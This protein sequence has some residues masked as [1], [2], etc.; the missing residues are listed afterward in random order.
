MADEELPHEGWPGVDAATIATTE[1][2]PKDGGGY[3]DDVK[4][5]GASAASAVPA[6]SATV[7]GADEH[8]E[9]VEASNAPADE[10]AEVLSGLGPE[11]EGLSPAE[12]VQKLESEYQAE[13]Q[14]IAEAKQY[15]EQNSRL[16]FELQQHQMR[17]VAQQEMQR[18]EAQRQQQWVAQQQAQQQRPKRQVPEWDSRWLEQLTTD[19]KGNVVLRP[20][21]DPSVL[22]KIHAYRDFKAKEEADF[23]N[24]PVKFVME[25]GGA[26]HFQQMA[27]QQAEQLVVGYIEN[28]QMREFENKWKAWLY[29]DHQIEPEQGGWQRPTAACVAI[30]QRANQLMQGG[31]RSR[32]QALKV[33]WG[34]FE[35][36]WKLSNPQ[37]FQPQPTNGAP[38]NGHTSTNGAPK[39][40]ETNE[41]ISRRVA[42]T[43][44]TQKNNRGRAA[45]PTLPASRPNFR[46]ML[47]A[48][49]SRA[50]LGPGANPDF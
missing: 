28:Q 4:V 42:A 20:G 49:L 41:Q 43:A 6:D 1:P 46:K 34:E 47:D 25:R 8:A 32:V 13:Q 5:P 37:F 16:Q 40:V 15:R 17:A 50:G 27:R 38:A 30:A 31:V 26:E 48:D 10:F 3:E 2:P 21:A 44:A 12:A 23:I 45:P 24:D 35:A 14:S 29:E 9:S 39:P 36:N 22:S 18:L 11:Y 33:A 7:K 19:E